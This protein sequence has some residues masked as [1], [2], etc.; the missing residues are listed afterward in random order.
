M[1]RSHV[2]G[3][4]SP[5]ILSAFTKRGQ[6]STKFGYK[7]LSSSN[8]EP[9][10]LS[11]KIFWK[12]H[13]LIVLYLVRNFLQKAIFGNVFLNEKLSDI[14][15]LCP[16]CSKENETTKHALFHC[17]FSRASWFCFSIGLL[18]HSIPIGQIWYLVEG[19]FWIISLPPCCEK[20]KM[21]LKLLW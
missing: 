13:P 18:S 4:F 11:W 6:L 8:N 9:N 1:R 7:I 21:T 20:K 15:K 19:K 3:N 2:R 12:T 17:N 14:S 10:E 5:S 16:I